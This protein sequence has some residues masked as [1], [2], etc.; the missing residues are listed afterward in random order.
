MEDCQREVFHTQEKRSQNLN[1]PVKCTRSNAWLG[2][3]YY[4]WDDEQDAVKWGH[5]SKR[6]TGKFQIYKAIANCEN[7]LNT[8]FNESHYRFWLRQIEKTAKVITKK[9]GI[10]PTIKDLNDYF[11]ERG[12]WEEVDGIMFQDIPEKEL[13]VERFFYRKRIQLAIYNLDI[14]KDFALYDE[15]KCR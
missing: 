6:Q 15:G 9:T 3:G 2:D 8:V 4:F 7:V 14:L 11:K 13:H 1:R 10:K 12:T 5:D